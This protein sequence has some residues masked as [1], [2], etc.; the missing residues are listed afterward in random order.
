MP[1]IQIIDK[2]GN[3]KTIA[4]ESGWSLMELLRDEGYDA[5]EGVCGGSMACATCHVHIHP[6]WKDKVIKQDNEQS[7]EEEDML[8]LAF[9]VNENSRLGCQ[10]RMD[11]EL[12]GMIVAIPGAP[13]NW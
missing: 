7:E 5:I 1:S 4:A 10:V 11:D 13:V 2:D 3:E 6:D 12:D 8:D 9:D